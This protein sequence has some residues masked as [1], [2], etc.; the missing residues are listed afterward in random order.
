[1]TLR[2]P[3]TDKKGMKN[4]AVSSPK[5]K[6][7]IVCVKNDYNLTRNDDLNTA[8]LGGQTLNSEGAQN[9]TLNSKAKSSKRFVQPNS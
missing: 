1:M 7:R 8:G 2:S 3:N 4:G 5:S 9:K 6:Y